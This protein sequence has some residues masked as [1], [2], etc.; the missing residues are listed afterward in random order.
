MD[1]SFSLAS[2]RSPSRND[3][4]FLTDR[5]SKS[6]SIQ[7]TGIKPKAL[8]P[9]SPEKQTPTTKPGSQQIFSTTSTKDRTAS[10][11]VGVGF[12]VSGGFGGLPLMPC[13]MN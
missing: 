5:S 4:N 11:G 13:E 6:D 8:F 2:A 9:D 3:D 10:G 7:L 1:D 12:G